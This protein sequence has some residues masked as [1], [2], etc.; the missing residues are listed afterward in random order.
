MARRHGYEVWE[1]NFLKLNLPANR[2]D[3]IFSN[4][5]LFHVPS[6]EF[7]GAAGIAR[8]AK[9]ARRPVQFEPAWP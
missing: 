3:G 4:A 2:F 5:A 7:A 6:Q 8:F 9:T 1:Q